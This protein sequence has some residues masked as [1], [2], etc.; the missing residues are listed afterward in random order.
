MTEKAK[1]YKDRPSSLGRCHQSGPRSS[2]FFYEWNELE[3]LTRES[4]VARL[5]RDEKK[6]AEITG[7]RSLKWAE[8]T[9]PRSPS[10]EVTCIT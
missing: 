1:M 8:V 6:W 4:T 2:F 5:G 10:A 3:E 9:G 7:Q